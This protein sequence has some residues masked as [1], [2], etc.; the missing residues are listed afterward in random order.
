[1]FISVEGFHLEPGA[2]PFA[3]IFLLPSGG[4]LD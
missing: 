4:N 1:M 3:E 2:K